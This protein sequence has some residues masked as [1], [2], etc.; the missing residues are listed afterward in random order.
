MPVW[1][2]HFQQFC[3]FRMAMTDAELQ[4]VWGKDEKQVKKLVEKDAKQKASMAASV[5]QVHLAEVAIKNGT[6]V[7][8]VWRQCRGSST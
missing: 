4:A 6:V 1:P 2:C 7:E 3:R 5:T 8:T